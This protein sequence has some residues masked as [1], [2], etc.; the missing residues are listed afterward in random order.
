MHH[1]LAAIL[2]LAQLPQDPA[3]PGSPVAAAQ[4]AQAEAR[5]RAAIAIDPRV[6][7]YHQSLARILE[8]Q[9]R[10]REA[11][12]S[13]RQSVILD[14]LSARNRAGYGELLLRSGSPSEAIPQLSAAAKL[15]P[16]S[17][18]VRKLLAGALIA[19]RRSQEAATVLKEARTLAPQ[20]S[21]IARALGTLSPTET[22]DGY[23]DFSDFEGDNAAGW[24]VRRVLQWVFAVVLAVAAIPLVV[25]IAGTV[26]LLL[27][28][29]Y[30]RLRNRTA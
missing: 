26:L 25:P 9:G 19:A 1:V 30:E 13:Q 23:H 2:L 4:L 28:L 22:G 16:S 6:A 24:W 5:Y 20:D 3:A 14:S 7:A 27:R 21:T 12:A 15:D 10:V 8:R 29:P 18:E 17:V 11:L